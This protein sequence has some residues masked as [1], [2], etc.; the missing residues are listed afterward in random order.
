MGE[1]LVG[2]WRKY[3]VPRAKCESEKEVRGTEGEVG[4]EKAVRG[5]RKCKN[6]GCPH[7]NQSPFKPKTVAVP[8]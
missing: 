5:C 1:R 8:I 3:E 7:L 2:D 4:N 6:G